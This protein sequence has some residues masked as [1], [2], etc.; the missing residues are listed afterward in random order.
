MKLHVSLFVLLIGL[1]LVGCH[2]S[3]GYSATAEIEIPPRGGARLEP[4]TFKPIPP[5]AQDWQG[6]FEVIESPEVVAPIITD[7]NLDRI[8]AKRLNSGDALPMEDALKYLGSRLKLE[9]K[10][11]T[12]IIRITVTSDVPQEAANI[13]NSIADH[14][15]AMRDQAEEQLSR[16]GIEVLKDQIAQQEQTSTDAK[17]RAT[18]NPHNDDL[19]K[20][21]QVSQAMLQALRLKLQQDEEDI[22]VT[23]SPFRIVSRAVPPPE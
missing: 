14:Y 3:G 12:W 23:T 18:Q 6:E 19:Q 8:W 7:L 15:K 10:S 21:S 11:G 17:A 5:T 13:A 9:G 22:K 2:R 16:R 4:G 20:Q 1:A